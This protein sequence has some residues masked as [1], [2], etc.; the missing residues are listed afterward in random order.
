MTVTPPTN[1]GFGTVVGQFI[2]D[3][4]DSG[5]AGQDPDFV[6]ASGTI[7]FTAS[8]PKVLDA[9]AAPNPVTIV[10]WQITG[11]LDSNGFLCTP[12]PS[13]PTIAGA[14]G[15]K[16]IATDDADLNPVNWTWTVSYSL[17][18]PDGSRLGS[19]R[20]HSMALPQGTTVDLTLVQPVESS[21]GNAI[22][23][24]SIGPTGPRGSDWFTGHGA[25]GTIVGSLPGDQYL[26][27]D[28]GDIYNLS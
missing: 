24:G 2:L 1:V 8:V 26:D 11:I 6:P 10:R 5:D 13:D 28:T 16:L 3:V 19:P 14:Q 15:I 25:P 27:L 20:G 9:G 23:V 4:V 7:T 22:L 21:T 17:V 12:D 18:G